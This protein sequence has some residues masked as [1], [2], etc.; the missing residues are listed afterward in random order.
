[1]DDVQ[2]DAL[3]PEPLEAAFK[4]SD[5]VFASWIELGGDEDLIA[6]DIAFAQPLP[7][8]CLIA[9]RLG[10]VDV[11]V[12]EL[13]CPPDGVDAL[14]AVR[15]LPDAKAEHWDRAAVAQFAC[16]YAAGGDDLHL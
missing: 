12:S 6:R 5:G 13:E 4:L 7:H 9:V 8:A 1:V 15:H 11:P 3:D 10:G 16:F 2:V 14:G